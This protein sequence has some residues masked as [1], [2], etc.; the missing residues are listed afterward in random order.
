MSN[1]RQFVTRLTACGALLALGPRLS[2]SIDAAPK[3]LKLLMLGG[4]GAIGPYHVRAAVMRGHRVAVFSRGIT[5]ADL[6]AS[7]ERL[8][9]DRNGNLAAIA[10]RDWDAV[11][12]LATF[13]PVWVRSLAQ[14]LGERIRHYTFIST[15]SVYDNPPLDRVTNED[16][17]VLAYTGKADPYAVVTHVGEDYG[18]LKVLCE[19]EAEKQFRGRTLVLRPGY[20]GGPGDSRALTYWAVR[21]S[22]GGNMLAGGESST[23]VQYLDVRDLAE[24]VIRLV[25]GRVT[26]T[27]NAVGPAQPLTLGGLVEAARATFAPASRITWV[28]AQ[29]LLSQRDPERWG[30]LL[31]W[32]HAV[33][34]IM[35]MSNERALAKGLTTRP[36]DITLRETLDW[37]RTQPHVEQESLITGFR[38]NADGTWSQNRSSW[39]EYLARERQILST[40]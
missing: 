3:P 8:T 29:W 27:F 31:F 6:P 28:P 25:E 24:W 26:G 10:N 11:I 36:I 4:T 18:A 14:S 22:K 13:G 9:G 40:R 37:Y 2:H 21:A 12:D 16:A 7:V 38:R 19:Q 39:A 20:I 35:R 5:R 32:S 34:P 17:P 33:G 30:T 1:R 23:P 15:V